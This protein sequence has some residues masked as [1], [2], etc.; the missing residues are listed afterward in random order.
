MVQPALGYWKLNV[1]GG[2][3]GNPERAGCGG[4][5]RGFLGNWKAEF[6]VYTGHTANPAAEFSVYFGHTANPAAELWGIWQIRIESDS[7]EALR[8]ASVNPSRCHP[9]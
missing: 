2:S 8:V 4:V 1:D 3:L 7:M 5:I 6:S 9:R